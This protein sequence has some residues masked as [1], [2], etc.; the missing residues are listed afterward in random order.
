M[1]DWTILVALALPPLWCSLSGKGYTP[2]LR[3]HYLLLCVS[4][5]QNVMY[6]SGIATMHS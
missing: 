5:V 2:L 3:K 4:A 1:T 6:C